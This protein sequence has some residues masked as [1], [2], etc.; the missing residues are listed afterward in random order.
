MK[1]VIHIVPQ[2]FLGNQ[3]IFMPLSN[4]GSVLQKKDETLKPY[5]KHL[6][7]EVTYT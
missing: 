6:L 4:L 2:I 5:S 1:T 7:L 3:K